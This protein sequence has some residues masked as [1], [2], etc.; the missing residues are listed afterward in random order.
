MNEVFL[1]TETQALT[2]MDIK[3]SRLLVL[4]LRSSCYW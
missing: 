2:M 4:K 1:D 3:L